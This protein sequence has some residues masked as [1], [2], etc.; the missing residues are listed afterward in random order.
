MRRS[1]ARSRTT[2]ISP[3]GLAWL[4]SAL[5]L[6]SFS[7]THRLAVN[8]MRKRSRDS[9]CRSTRDVAGGAGDDGDDAS[10][11]MDDVDDTSDDGDDASDDGDVSDA[12]ELA[13]C[14]TEQPHGRGE[15]SDSVAPSIDSAAVAGQ[16][17]GW[18]FERDTAALGIS[19]RDGSF[20]MLSATSG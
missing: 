11:A 2:D 8:L 18:R 3:P 17:S 7:F 15:T 13:R 14:S 16:S 19:E 5:A 1:R 20:R 12:C 6:S 9:G 10:D 4:I